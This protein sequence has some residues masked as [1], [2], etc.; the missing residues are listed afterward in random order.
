MRGQRRRVFYVAKSREKKEGS[1]DERL[2]ETDW[3]ADGLISL[4]RNTEDAIG[5]AQIQS[6]W[7]VKKRKWEGDRSSSFSPVESF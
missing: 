2:A 6:Q 1:S 4:R 5:D 3:P 7:C